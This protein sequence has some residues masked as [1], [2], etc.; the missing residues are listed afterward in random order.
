V[1][2]H[3]LTAPVL[4]VSSICIDSQIWR[5]P[6]EVIRSGSVYYTCATHVLLTLDLVKVYEAAFLERAA[7]CRSGTS[8]NGAKKGARGFSHRSGLGYLLEFFPQGKQKSERAMRL[9]V[10]A[11]VC[12]RAMY[13]FV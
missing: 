1:T 5:G 12:V 11:S 4:R 6:D 9:S 10:C 7:G 8:K 2:G 3:P 13:V